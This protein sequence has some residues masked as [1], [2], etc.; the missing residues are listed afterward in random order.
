MRGLLQ[1][2]VKAR[3]LQIPQGMALGGDAVARLGS[4]VQWPAV[5]ETGLVIAMGA[6]AADLAWSLATP[7]AWS[8]TAVNAVR[9]GRAPQ[10]SQDIVREFVAFDPFHRASALLATAP[11]ELG[12]PETLLNIQLFGLRAGADG[13]G[14][15]A[16]IGLP[17]NTQGV[18]AVGQE[19]MAGV[20]LESVQTN[21]VLL[22]RNG[23]METLPLDKDRASTAGPATV[24]TAPR[25]QNIAALLG[26]FRITPRGEGKLG[27]IIESG[28]TELLQKSGLAVGD[29][30]LSVNGSAVSDMASLAVIATRLNDAPS[31]SLE[32]DRNGQR[33]LHTLAI[34]QTR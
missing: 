22:R 27:A 13:K 5:A 9:G 14:G 10:A 34:D 24:T 33:N 15:S 30:L 25:M 19:V 1:W 29:V 16:I 21:R 31:I 18:F 11:S 17:D 6:L 8:T 7:T 2:A 23:V 32:I 12:A 26:G 3:H 28:N 20:Y 4:K